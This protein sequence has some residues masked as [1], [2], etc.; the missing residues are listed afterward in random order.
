MR[1]T[2]GSGSRAG[3]TPRERHQGQHADQQHNPDLLIRDPH[4]M[5]IRPSSR[6]VTGFAE[7]AEFRPHTPSPF[8]GAGP[9]PARAVA[10]APSGNRAD[11]AHQ[12]LS[13]LE[14]EG[15]EGI[16]NR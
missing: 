13:L 15:L 3:Q 10:K 12:P 7:R 9:Q 4:G 1:G 2:A 6:P 11:R 5:I 16:G 8:S 14:H